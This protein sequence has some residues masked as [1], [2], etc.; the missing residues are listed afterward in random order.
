MF[1]KLSVLSYSRGQGPEVSRGGYVT[2]AVYYR[3]ISE[4]LDAA[5]REHE[6]RSG[7]V[8]GLKATNNVLGAGASTFVT[9]LMTGSGLTVPQSALA[10]G[11]V[12]GVGA[13]GVWVFDKAL[14][15]VGGRYDRELQG[16]K[17][18]VDREDGAIEQLRIDMQLQME[19]LAA[20]ITAL[21]GGGS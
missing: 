6:S 18:R 2:R 19:A 9:G 15:A 10:G 14:D 21:E 12:A 4:K 17:A 7:W 20:R 13:L 11:I 16:T 3:G 5:F 8:S 1:N